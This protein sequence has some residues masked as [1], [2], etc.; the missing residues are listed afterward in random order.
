MGTAQQ[1]QQ[2]ESNK[3]RE[4]R[5]KEVKGI[6]HTAFRVPGSHTESSHVIGS[7]GIRFACSLIL[8]RQP[9]NQ[10]PTGK[11]TLQKQF[12]IY[13]ASQTLDHERPSWRPVV[14]FNIIKAVRMILDELDYQFTT[15]HVDPDTPEMDPAHIALEVQQEIAQIRAKLLPLVALESTLATELSGGVSI[16]GGRADAFVRS[17]WQAVASSKRSSLELS[18][19]KQSE[20]ANLVAKTLVTVRPDVDELW[21]HPAVKSLVELRK[22]RLDES[23]PL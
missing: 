12:Q 21:K 15:K 20:A 22:L 17:G 18:T 5:R 11:S 19:N 13:Y 14:Y 1:H 7:G 23:A 8:P 3:R 10:Y 9:T 16:A 2:K 4:A 6:S